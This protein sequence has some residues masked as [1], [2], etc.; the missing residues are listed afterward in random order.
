VWVKACSEISI[1]IVSKPDIRM[2][3]ATAR[4]R[5]TGNSDFDQKLTTSRLWYRAIMDKHQWLSN[6]LYKEG[7]LWCHFVLVSYGIVKMRLENIC[8]EERL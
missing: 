8:N 3:P 6:L 4:V 7:S 1:H 2:T 5:L